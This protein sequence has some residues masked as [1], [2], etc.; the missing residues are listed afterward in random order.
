MSA[1]ITLVVPFYNEAGWIGATLTSL[2]GQ[3][4]RRFRI[5]L[6]DNGSTD[7]GKA[8]AV[9][10]C[11]RMPD[12]EVLHLS[13][14][15][16]GKTFALE[17]GINRV[18]TAFVA[19]I[20]AD[21]IY[22]PGYT[23]NILRLFQANPK[24][25]A[26]MA[27]DLHGPHGSRQNRWRITKILCKAWIFRNKCHAGGY[28]QAFRSEA[29][30]RAGGFAPSIWPYTLEDHEIIARI[31]KYGSVI[32]SSDHFCFP[33]DRRADRRSVDWTRA[34]RLLYKLTP[35]SL[36]VAFFHRFLAPQLKARNAL[37]ARL[38]Q[39]TWT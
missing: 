15:K 9:E 30:A 31:G 38:R 27:V 6:V 26:V 18:T 28:A 10:A 35:A 7:G 17:A 1:L 36:N 4:D 5:I 20:D 39:K 2:S 16:P 32:Y 22:P 8:E 24:A 25:V 34:E 19:T 14:T 37:S 21:T 13:V 3:L 29:L 12:I 33:S 11:A 23:A